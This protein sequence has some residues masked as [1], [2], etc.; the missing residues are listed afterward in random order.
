MADAVQSSKRELVQGGGSKM[1]KRLFAVI[2][3]AFVLAGIVT[4]SVFARD[5]SLV[6]RTAELRELI[7]GLPQSYESE[8]S[9]GQHMYIDLKNTH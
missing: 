2:A 7:Q 8:D 4:G 5:I 9:E 3:S 1:R 6:D